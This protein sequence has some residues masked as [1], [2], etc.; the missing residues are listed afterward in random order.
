MDFKKAIEVAELNARAL[1]PNAKDFKLEAAVIGGRNYEISLSY[2]HS[3]QSPLELAGEKK[4]ANNLV[5]LA[6]FMGSRREFKTFL[7]EEGSFDFK[8]FK[9][10]KEK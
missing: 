3:G 8:G 1:L 6:S 9:A 10:Y 7:V 4:D 5:K 2:Y